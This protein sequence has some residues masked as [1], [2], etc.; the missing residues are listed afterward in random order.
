MSHYKCNPHISIPLTFSSILLSPITK[1]SSY[2]F[3]TNSSS[4]TPKS[5]E[6]Q[7]SHPT[8]DNFDDIIDNT[9][10]KDDVESFKDNHKQSTV[11]PEIPIRMRPDWVLIGV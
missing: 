3:T 7:S 11:D 5:E 8:N 4:S 2:S 9:D 6:S 10:N 1:H